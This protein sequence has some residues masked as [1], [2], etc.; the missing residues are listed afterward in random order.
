M[1]SLIKIFAAAL[2]S[3]FF[4]SCGEDAVNN[5]YSGGGGIFEANIS[6]SDYE[7]IIAH[8]SYYNPDYVP[9]GY[10]DYSMGIK[11]TLKL[12]DPSVR[13][14]ISR[15]VISYYGRGYDFN[16]QELQ[17]SYVDSIGGYVFTIID[18]DMID[19]PDSFLWSVKLYDAENNSSMNYPLMVNSA[20]SVSFNVVNDWTSADGLQFTL[21]NYTQQNSGAIVE[22]HFLNSDYEEIDV[23][24]SGLSNSAW[25]VTNTPSEAVLFYYVLSDKY[26]NTKRKFISA[27]IPI[28]NRFPDNVEFINDINNPDKIEYLKELDKILV[29]SSSEN[30]LILLN[31]DDNSI[32]WK[33]TLNSTPNTFVY[34][35]ERG[36]I[37]LGYKDGA[38]DSV[39]PADGS[40][41][42]LFNCF[43]PIGLLYP[44]E[45]HLY[46]FRE[47]SSSYF[48]YSFNDKS[49]SALTGFGFNYITDAKYVPETK[50]FYAREDHEIHACSLNTNGSLAEFSSAI[51][52]ADISSAA[53]I[54]VMVFNY[55]NTQIYIGDGFISAAPTSQNPAYFSMTKSTAIFCSMVFLN[56]TDYAALTPAYYHSNSLYSSSISI[57][58]GSV[59]K[60][61]RIGMAGAPKMVFYKDDILKIYSVQGNGR[62]IAQKFTVQEIINSASGKI[63]RNRKIY[64]MK[65]L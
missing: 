4:I 40:S 59:L 61:K 41:K 38:V 51:I 3:A 55:N 46:I 5:Y 37:Y 14:S 1:R 65:K 43:Y 64:T 45:N 11:F 17:E 58:S 16:K 23:Y 9:A 8:K 29:L 52:G 20:R 48:Y 27:K 7:V 50:T 30:E 60:G 10:N 33:K 54:S 2:F 35:A 25:T 12:K 49:L 24:R 13:E 19:Y 21:T 47:N 28:K 22:T 62:L 44:A 6:E 42:R 26:G 31:Y 57:Y 36:A 18:F 39:N 34:S 56:Q 32:A 53:L 15:M 63:N